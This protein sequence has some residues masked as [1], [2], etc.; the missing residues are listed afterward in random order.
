MKRKFVD[1]YKVLNVDRTASQMQIKEAYYRLARK[2]HPDINV[3]NDVSIMKFTI[4]NEAYSILGDLDK[5]LKYKVLLEKHDEAVS[6][7]KF[8]RKLNEGK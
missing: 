2:Y 3:F 7:A 6:K 8:R 4:I 5:R 1:Y